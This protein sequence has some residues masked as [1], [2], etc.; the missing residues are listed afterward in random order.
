MPKTWAMF[1][2]ETDDC[3][4]I[5]TRIEIGKAFNIPSFT[6]P[7]DTI[8][9]NRIYRGKYVFVQIPELD[10]EKKK[11]AKPVKKIEL[12]KWAKNDKKFYD[13]VM[14]ARAVLLQSNCCAL[15]DEDNGKDFIK[16][17]KI[18]GI[19]AKVRKTKGK[20]ITGRG[21]VK[22]YDILEVQ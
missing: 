9:E 3:I 10:E 22:H 17:L 16:P 15:A 7:I 14:T 20:E 11:K 19:N 8:Y 12:P 13:K 5:G 2:V 21:I 1:D 6:R 4:F 18:L